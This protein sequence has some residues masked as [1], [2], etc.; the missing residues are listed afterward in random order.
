MLIFLPSIFYT[1]V[2]IKDN[3]LKDQSCV[4][5]C[6]RWTGNHETHI[7][8]L[9]SRYINWTSSRYIFG[10]FSKILVACHGFVPDNP[11][12]GESEF[13]AW[14]QE[15]LPEQAGGVTATLNTAE[16]TLASVPSWPPALLSSSSVPAT[17][18]TRYSC[19]VKTTPT[20]LSVMTTQYS[21]EMAPT[22]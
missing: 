13:K 12:T 6:G 15:F 21:E 9:H 7:H 10:I 18:P 11:D 19:S 8:N 5:V 1:G 17:F 22:L 16:T 14:F 4:R 20:L 2:L 3:Y